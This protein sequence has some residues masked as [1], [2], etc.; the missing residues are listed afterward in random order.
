MPELK[1]FKRRWHTATDILPI[2]MALLCI[3]HVLWFVPYA[4]GA[5]SI[6][7]TG[8]RYE[9]SHANELRLANYSLFALF[10]LAAANE[11]VLTVLGLRGGPFETKKRRAM[12][13]LL[14]AEVVIWGLLLGFT[15]YA[16]VIVHS[17]Q[18]SKE[19]WSNNPCLYNPDVYPL[20]CRDR[21]GKGIRQ[22]SAACQRTLEVGPNFFYCWLDWMVFGANWASEAVTVIEQYFE[23]LANVEAETTPGGISVNT[24][25]EAVGRKVVE[26]F[27]CLLISTGAD[28]SDV[29][30]LFTFTGATDD[31]SLAAEEQWYDDFLADPD[32]NC[33]AILADFRQSLNFTQCSSENRPALWNQTL[34]IELD[35]D[36]SD[37]D[38]AK[39]EN[40]SFITV[41]GVSS[42]AEY[43]AFLKEHPNV[44]QYYNSQLLQ[45]IN[46]TGLSYLG[47]SGSYNLSKAS[48]TPWF[49]CLNNTCQQQTI[50]AQECGEWAQILS[51]P[52]PKN[53]RRF[54]EILVITSWTVLG[55]T[56]LVLFVCFNAFPDYNDVH[57]WEGTVR[58]IDQLCLCGG[59][60]SGKATVSGS[61]MSVS[62][63]IAKSLN[64]LFGGVDMDP[65][66]RLMGIYLV[67]ERQHRRRQQDIQA[68]LQSAGYLK[69]PADAK[70]RGSLRQ[71]LSRFN[72]I[73]RRSNRRR[74]GSSLADACGVPVAA[75]SFGGEDGTDA[76]RAVPLLDGGVDAA[77]VEAAAAHV[78]AA[79]DK[80][81]AE[82]GIPAASA[83][84]ATGKLLPSPFDV[85]NPLPSTQRAP[86]RQPP[87]LGDARLMLYQHSMI[88]LVSSA[89]QNSQSLACDL[90][91]A[92]AGQNLKS[93]A[94]IEEA[95]HPGAE[96]EHVLEPAAAPTPSGGI[97]SMGGLQ[98]GQQLSKAVRVVARY[99]PLLTPSGCACS[100]K[101]SGP[102]LSPQQAA[103][104]YA[105]HLDAVDQATLREAQR[106]SRFAVASYGLQSVIW[107]QGK[108]P[109]MCLANANRLV[110]CFKRPFGL[111]DK[112]RKRNFD[113]IIEITG[114]Q[115]ADLLYVSYTNVAGGVLPY[116]LM[117]HRPSKSVVVS[118][119]GTV[120]MEDLITDL[121]SNPVDVE[122][123]VPDWVREEAQQRK[124]AGIAGDPTGDSLKAHIG[125]VSSASAILK[126]M[127]DRGLLREMLLS[128]LLR[129]ATMLGRDSQQVI[130]EFLQHHKPQMPEVP[131]QQV[132]SR[133]PAMCSSSALP[134]ALKGQG[135]VAGDRNDSRSASGG[136]LDE[137][138]AFHELERRHL[139]R[140]HTLREEQEE[141]D[142]PLDRAHAILRS[143]LQLDGWKVVVTGH[144]LGA[145]VAT[146]LGMQ[147]RERFTDLQCWA[148]NPPGGLLSWELAQIAERYCTSVVVGKDVIS[149]LSFNTSKRVVDEMVVSL[150]R[151]KRPK[152]KV[153]FDVIL[154]RRK[155]PASTPPTFCGFD[156]IA[157]EALQLVE[158]YYRASHLHMRSADTTEMYPPGRLVFLRPFKGK[159]KQQTVWDAVWIDAATLISEG[160]LVTPTMMAHHRLYVLDEAFQSIFSG[161][162]AMEVAAQCEQGEED[163][164]RP[165]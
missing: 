109:N 61:D 134:A 154:G 87:R 19:C 77:A 152:L 162:A 135:L 60:L 44:F 35:V 21:R 92:E 57:S 111:E 71:A 129:T 16:T 20:A 78:D 28:S 11:A 46:D 120:S 24:T 155:Q 94:E 15:V 1:L 132:P 3:F 62:H 14:Y 51:L 33:T 107:A 130:E 12:T 66:D 124:D 82:D 93:L 9:C 32:K 143:K 160:I 47:I 52:L 108:R 56:A 113:A 64:L 86:P 125:I 50:D 138:P 73:A 22:L 85:D 23:Q 153:L 142:L 151:C 161:E 49:S 76:P 6:E 157:P 110:K 147:L 2:M 96:P 63:E 43:N 117:L 26:W 144:S 127:E 106:I 55:I 165:L 141:V 137:D 65:T 27:V 149:R 40:S 103:D 72:F 10:G 126:D 80:A 150:A 30:E 89:S 148:F 118:V 122:N 84:Q 91:V 145:A 67:S 90:S 59:G 139:S 115:P 98:P 13:P 70:Q 136:Q 58:N 41:P 18:V 88:R 121:L 164:L 42:V 36:M 53:K 7:S 38:F 4:T 17:P 48:D 31:P 83:A 100:D 5:W 25:D 74:A 81:A 128:K 69:A 34:G 163:V 158:Q 95:L 68:T 119:R 131:K 159:R 123:W 104:I 114:V 75:I 156:E 112:F 105:G 116:L 45:A 54:F 133:S 37:Q 99:H 97:A 39:G 101:L 140:L 146:L 79:G 102:S 8:L 29:D